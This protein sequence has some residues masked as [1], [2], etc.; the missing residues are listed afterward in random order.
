[1]KGTKLYSIFKGKCPVCHNG[2]L[3]KNKN[4]YLLSETL[5]MHERC[6]HCDTKFKIEPSFFYGAMYVSYGVGIAFAVAAFIISFFLLNLGRLNSFLVITGTLVFFLPVILRLSR[7]I[8]INFFF[9]F[10]PE[11]AS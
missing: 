2:D 5:K 4:P 9:K 6:S 10:D 11:K 7:N 8:W 3:Y 1:M